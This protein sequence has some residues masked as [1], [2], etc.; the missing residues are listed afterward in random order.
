MAEVKL[1]SPGRIIEGEYEGYFVT[2][3]HDAD[4]TGGFYILL[5]NDL[6]NPTDGGD[7]W[8]ESRADVES[9]FKASQWT[10]VWLD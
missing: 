10:V 5:V 1:E 6:T 8:V 3:H 7:F 2:V 9:F 4:A